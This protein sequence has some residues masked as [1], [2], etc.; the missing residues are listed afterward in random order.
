MKNYI[1]IICILTIK[2]AFSQNQIDSLDYYYKNQNFT[3][4]IEYGQKKI[5][6]LESKNLKYT[7]ECSITYG[8]L[9]DI[10]RET[11]DFK[12]A[13]ISYLNEI[14]IITKVLGQ[15]NIPVSNSYRCLADVYNDMKDYLNAENCYKKA[16]TIVE[17][18]S[19][20]NSAEYARM[21]I[22]F[23]FYYGN[24]K[25]YRNAEKLF[26][27]IIYLRKNNNSEEDLIYQNS[28]VSYAIYFNNIGNI[29]KAIELRIK[30]YELQ[31]NKTT[32]E[33]VLRVTTNIDALAYMS[34]SIH[35]NKLDERKYFEESVNLK[36]KFIGV[37]NIEYVKSLIN[38]ARTYSNFNESRSI[39]IESCNILKKLN[40]TYS[41]EYSMCLDVIAAGYCYE[42][43][44]DLSE[45]YYFQKIKIDENIYGKLNIEYLYDL[46][47]LASNYYK[48]GDFANAE[49]Y[50]LQSIDESVIKNS[51]QH[52]SNLI[53]VAIFYSTFD[54]NKC[55]HYLNLA[56]KKIQSLTE[57]IKSNFNY[58]LLQGWYI[59]YIEKMDY[60]TA[61]EYAIKK[62]ELTKKNKMFGSNSSA[63]ARDLTDLALTYN[64]IGNLD[65]RDDLYLK[66]YEI[67]KNNIGQNPINDAGTLLHMYH[68]YNR[69]KDSVNAEKFYLLFK[70]TFDE[71]ITENSVG[72]SNLLFILINIQLDKEFNQGNDIYVQKL[73]NEN[74]LNLMNILNFVSYKEY[75][76]FI[77]DQKG[78]GFM[79]LNFLKEFPTKYPE[80]NIGCYEN[81]LLIKNLSLRNQQR[82]AKSIQKSGDTILQEKYK[83]FLGNKKKLDAINNL[84]IAHRPTDY[85]QLSTT[86]ENLEKELTRLS[87]NFAEA[88]NSLAINWKQIQDRLQTNEIA[89]DLVSFQ[90]Y[91][92]KWTDSIVYSA[93]VVGKNFK[94]PKY[95]PLFEQKQLEFLLYRNQSQTDNKKIDNQYTDKS[96]S[97]LFLKPLKN[98]LNCITT[99][100][101]S[102][103]GLGHQINF[104]A[105]PVSENQTLG[106]KFKLHILGSTTEIIDYKM[107]SIDKK[108]NLEL[109][110]YGNIDYNKTDVSNLNNK[111]T[112][113]E[114]QDFVAETRN[115][116][117]ETAMHPFLPGSKIEI[118]EIYEIAK[119]NSFNA[120]IIEDRKATE[121]SIKALDGR[122]T[123]FVLHLA[124]HGFF[125]PDLK[126]KI[127]ENDIAGENTKKNYYSQAS[128]PMLRSGLI[129]AGANKFW[130][131]PA[132]NSTGDD[133]IL[134]ASEISNLDLSAC[135]LVALSACETGLG[136]I[137]GSEGVFGLQR[138]FKMAGVKNIIMSLW[139]VDDAK[140]VEFFQIFYTNCLTDKSIHDAFLNT[141][142]AM[143]AKY[144][145]YY[146]AGFVLLE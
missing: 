90:Y 99:V 89:I 133:G 104:S 17:N 40:M 98:E 142:S 136:D 69:K 115:V 42:A 123:P 116:T 75:N 86:T 97:D 38:L 67:K 51:E 24:K 65:K 117:N 53:E 60:Y 114:N 55:F 26:D 41:K 81:E 73:L 61:M 95:I 7:P 107:A 36:K 4:A 14:E 126:I 92:K 128:D 56:E 83:Q 84:T 134:T 118:N 63:F 71:N 139:K 6:I 5:K 70:K 16:I 45:A 50:Y 125:F 33:N 25:D 143:K 28:I 3:K 85:D 1:T 113:A 21:L 96:I 66:I 2:M 130:G 62:S 124:T 102:P 100:Y 34:D 131:K 79:P 105:L 82:I 122:T 112:I 46:K 74:N 88:K 49:N 110:L 15:I 39:Y 80:I 59:Y 138:A 23:A 57:K 121:E 120:K 43:K 77:N 64:Y 48:K 94:V 72:Y 129:L 58:Y 109:L 19:G 135:Q 91:N 37:Y 127:P 30:L 10:Y 145:T 29:H 32:Q 141:Q 108:N 31:K 140:T 13:E 27:E 76:G 18:K 132:E 47:M 106:E 54:K 22:N 44:Y 111:D 52:V 11:K 144:P 9:G 78:I 87:S 68:M 35:N 8:S 103:S 119:V 101:L 137:N 146:W 20:K 12:L 93:F